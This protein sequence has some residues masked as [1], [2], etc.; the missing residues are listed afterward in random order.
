MRGLFWARNARKTSFSFRINGYT[1]GLTTFDY[2]GALFSGPCSFSAKFSSDTG[3]CRLCSFGS[4]RT[5]SGLW[6]SGPCCDVVFPMYSSC[7]SASFPQAFKA[8]RC[9]SRTR[10][11]TCRKPKVS[12]VTSPFNG[13]PFR[14]STSGSKG[15]EEWVSQDKVL[16]SEPS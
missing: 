1:L 14:Q 12:I 13:H 6:I 2:L 5:A 10:S 4:S 11:C 8:A 9:A 7:P 3:Q 15:P 16:F